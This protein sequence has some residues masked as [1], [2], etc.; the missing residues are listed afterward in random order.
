MVLSDHQQLLARRAIIAPRDVRE[1]AVSNV[2][3]IDQL[4]AKR[5][6][7]LNNSSAHGFYIGGFCIYAK[8]AIARRRGM[9]AGEWLYLF[10]LRTC[11]GNV[12]AQGQK[13]F[14]GVG[15]ETQT[16]RC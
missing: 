1:P 15:Q 4:V 8:S 16:D 13:W 5:T 14:L 9:I 6:R 12:D 10:G 3:P 2:H 11:L 7:G